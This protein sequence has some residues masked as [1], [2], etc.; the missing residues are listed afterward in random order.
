[1]LFDYYELY[2]CSERTSRNYLSRYLE[3][4]SFDS[5]GCLRIS[6]ACDIFS[7]YCFTTA[8]RGGMKNVEKA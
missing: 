8:L 7:D 6:H 1:M 2:V 4:D 5:V 3:S